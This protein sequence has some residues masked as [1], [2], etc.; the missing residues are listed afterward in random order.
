MNVDRRTILSGAVLSGIVSLAGASLLTPLPAHAAL[1]GFR[2]AG[3]DG[4]DHSAYDALLRAHVIADANSYN[5]VDYRGVKSQLGALKSYVAALEAANPVSL[6]PNE[7]HAYWINLYNAKTL[8]VVAEA[9]PVS[10]IKKVNLGGSFLFGSGPW[11]A[12]L[13]TVNG[14]DL[15][16]DDIEHEIVRGLFKNPMSHYGLNCASYSCPNLAARAFT[17]AN[18]DA[19]LRQNAVDYV[20]HPRG[21]KIE[22]NRITASKIYSW[23][24]SDFGGKGKLKAHWSGLAAPEKAARIAGASIAGYDYDWSINAL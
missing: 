22:N 13:M 15:S 6:S 12:K 20:N 4:F 9:F 16:L 7:A 5:R 24:A 14:V 21:V 18:L 10:S 19:Q 11:K 23:Y 3:S 1:T 8:E 2:P 17:G